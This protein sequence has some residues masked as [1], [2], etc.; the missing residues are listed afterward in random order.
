MRAKLVQGMRQGARAVFV[1]AGGFARR[2]GVVVVG[3][4]TGVEGAA[5]DKAHVFVQHVRVA[6][7]RDIVGDGERQPQVVVRTLC[8]H[9]TVGGRM[10]PVLHVGLHELLRGAAQQ[11]FAG[12]VGTRDRQRHRV[13]QLVAKAIRAA[14]LVMAAARPYPACQCLVEQP[15]VGQGVQGGVR[16][17]DTYHVQRVA[18]L[19]SDG[20][21]FIGGLA[22]HPV[23]ARQGPG[24]RFALRGVAQQEQHLL[25][26]AVF[27]RD[28]DLD[29]GAGVQA[30][31]RAS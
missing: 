9:A 4:F 16:G 19:L 15:A 3:R 7:D 30:S 12:Q 2:R 26:L 29:G 6:R 14:G 31:A 5:F 21:E 1:Q 22:G 13:L 8:A 27:Q 11:M 25:L 17:V 23:A 10:P 28:G 18:P 20:H 24:L